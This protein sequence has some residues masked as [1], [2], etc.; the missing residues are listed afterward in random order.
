[1]ILFHVR[2]DSASRPDQRWDGRPS[3]IGK[4]LVVQPQGGGKSPRHA[5]D[6]LGWLGVSPRRPGRARSA[7]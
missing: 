2:W 3:A 7:G 1:M 6:K 5:L 4:L